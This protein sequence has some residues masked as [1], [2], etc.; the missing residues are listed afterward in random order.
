MDRV[1]ITINAADYINATTIYT[2]PG[3][4][5]TQR[6]NSDDLFN[7][8]FYRN[9]TT[10]PFEVDWINVTSAHINFTVTTPALSDIKLNVTGP[11]LATVFLDGVDTP[12]VY[13][14]S[15][16]FIEVDSA[17]EIEI[18]FNSYSRH[19]T[20]ELGMEDEFDL[21]GGIGL[22]DEL[23]MDEVFNKGI[24]KGIT[25]EL[26]MEDGIT[27]GRFADFTDELGM[28][29]SITIGRFVA[30][31]DEL[32]LEDM[33]A[34]LSANTVNLTDELGMEDIIA[35]MAGATINFTDELGMEDSI[36]LNTG[37]TISFTNEL[38]MEDSFAIMSANTVNLIDE[39][40]MEDLMLAQLSVIYFTDELGMEDTLMELPPPPSIFNAIVLSLNSPEVDRLGGVYAVICPAETVLT[41]LLTNG[42]FVC[43]PIAD[44][45]P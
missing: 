36:T 31:V 44:V 24:G 32:G 8:T 42:T 10:A 3:G 21:G 7:Y 17:L 27:L 16:N 11:V 33:F 43:T 26:G 1:N 45:L 25:D 12:F 34:V 23:G 13:D 40:G 2:S 9:S 4:F 30:F 19:F 18:L 28:E 5:L 38:G 39:L 37:Y 35:I 14:G 20:D 22:T 41:G 29:D 6:T 15:V